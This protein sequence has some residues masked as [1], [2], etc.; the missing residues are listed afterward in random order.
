MSWEIDSKDRA[1]LYNLDEDA[2]Q[3]ISQLSKKVKLNR[4]VVRYR[5]DRM[6][7]DGVIQKFLAYIPITRFGYLLTTFFMSF[8]DSSIRD[9]EEVIRFLSGKE[10]VVWVVSANGRFDLGFT[11]CAKNMNELATFV[12]EFRDK[13]R[14]FI[15][16]FQMADVVSLWRFPR[17]YLLENDDDTWKPFCFDSTVVRRDLDDVDRKILAALGEDGRMRAVEIARRVG[18]SA[19]AVADRIS[20]MRKEKMIPGISILLNNNSIKRKAFKS[21]ITFHNVKKIEKK[22][23]DYCRQNRNVVQVKRTLGPWEYEVDLELESE[24]ELR[25]LH[26]KLKEKFPDSIRSTSFVSVYR[27]HKFD[28]GGFLLG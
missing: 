5:I 1:I 11:M 13:F 10:L 22:F 28:M 23:L 6:E 2:R 18:V 7:Q 26:N 21:F 8:Q 15:T 24:D 9:E 3:P 12:A 17:G 27:V 19:D 4:E 16:D 14:N 25:E 20:K